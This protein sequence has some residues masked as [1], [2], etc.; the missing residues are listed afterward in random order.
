MADICKIGKPQK[1]AK[2]PS[3]NCAS[4]NEDISCFKKIAGVLTGDEILKHKIIDL[5]NSYYPGI[6]KNINA[7]TYDLRLGDAHYIYDSSP[8]K[9]PSNW[10][11]VFIGNNKNLEELNSITYGFE[12]RCGEET[13]KIPPFGSA[14]VQLDEI[15]D[16]LSVAK[17]KNILIVGRFDLKL[18]KVN[19]ALISQ[20]ATQVEPCYKGKLFCFLHNISN[21]YIEINYQESIATIEFSYVSCFYNE[22]KR[23]EIINNIIESNEKRYYGNFC[24][25]GEGIKDIRWFYTKGHLP[26]DCGLAS[27]YNSIITDLKNKEQEIQKWRENTE[28]SIEKE[29]G[30][31]INKHETIKSVSNDV[32]EHIN[33]NKKLI[34]YWISLV[35]TIISVIASPVI[36]FLIDS[37]NEEKRSQSIKINNQDE[38]ILEK[39]FQKYLIDRNI[40]IIGDEND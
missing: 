3:N 13:I 16:T 34:I 32:V 19:Q 24:Y 36:T 37:K 21:Q 7:T 17:E 9:K 26:I 27:F 38:E 30:I 29:F 8:T 23:K 31:F 33:L 5:N 6:K 18:S 28:S 22:I 4:C 1:N 12:K 14:L 15:V 25:Q 20:Q 2:T 35:I 10:S 11:L 40:Y 39:L